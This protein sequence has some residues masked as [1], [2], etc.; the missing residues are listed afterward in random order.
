MLC[1]VVGVRHTLTDHAA[2]TK[3][4]GLENKTKAGLLVGTVDL[5]LSD[6][7]RRGEF[8]VGGRS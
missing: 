4:V 1:C 2:G 7:R 8:L 5:N 6:L 3:S